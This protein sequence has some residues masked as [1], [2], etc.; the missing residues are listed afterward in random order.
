MHFLGAPFM[1][2][3]WGE[4][5]YTRQL[6]VHGQDRSGGFHATFLYGVALLDKCILEKKQNMY[7]QYTG[8]RD[9]IWS[10]TQ[11][12][13]NGLI[14]LNHSKMRRQLQWVQVL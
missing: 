13:S 5:V 12:T 4:S 3:C 1:C 2:Q 6:K 9:L 7:S 10:M 8:R 11:T 14:L